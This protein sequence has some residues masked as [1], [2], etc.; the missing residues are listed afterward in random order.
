[1]KNGNKH[2]KG[3]QFLN[4]SK[5]KLYSTCLKIIITTGICIQ[6]RFLSSLA[7][8]KQIFENNNIYIVLSTDAPQRHLHSS[9]VGLNPVLR[10]RLYT[11]ALDSFAEAHTATIL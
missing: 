6:K 2:F 8:P 7:R 3:L 1:M 11:G 10:V 4:L 9:R 5:I